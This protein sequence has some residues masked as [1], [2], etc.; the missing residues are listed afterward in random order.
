[1]IKRGQTSNCQNNPD[2]LPSHTVSGCEVITTVKAQKV[3]H[4]ESVGTPLSDMSWFRVHVPHKCLGGSFERSDNK[5]LRMCK[6]QQKG[7]SPQK[8]PQPRLGETFTHFQ[9]TFN[10]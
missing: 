10:L 7:F 3:L 9:C 2:C 5:L 8:V 4:Y 1:M 6:V